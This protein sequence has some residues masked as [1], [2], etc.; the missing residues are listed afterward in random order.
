MIIIFPGYIMLLSLL[1]RHSIQNIE[2]NWK[3]K[4][5]DTETWKFKIQKDENLVL[6][7]E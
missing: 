5:K 1:R 3:L 6:P 4:A 2:Q 7:N